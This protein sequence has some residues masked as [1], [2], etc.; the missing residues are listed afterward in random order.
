MGDPEHRR[1][2]RGSVGAERAHRRALRVTGSTTA[3]YGEAGA[4]AG[5]D[6]AAMAAAFFCASTRSAFA[7]VNDAVKVVSPVVG[8][9]VTK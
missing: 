4:D 9:V 7:S 6:P 1:L 2:A 5:A 3:L 8:S